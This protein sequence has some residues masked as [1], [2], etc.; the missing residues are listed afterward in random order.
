MQYFLDTIVNNVE[1]LV[2]KQVQDKHLA[3]RLY[4]YMFHVNEG[5]GRMEDICG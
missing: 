2:Y 5:N 1:S 4:L 3:K